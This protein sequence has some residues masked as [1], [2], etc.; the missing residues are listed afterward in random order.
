[1]KEQNLNKAY[2][3]LKAVCHPTRLS[4]ICLLSTGPR[5]VNEIVKALKTTQS[6]VSQ[7]LGIM[8]EKDILKTEKIGNQVNYSIANKKLS[9]LTKLLEELFCR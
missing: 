6:N 4:I 3:C 9:K 7:H 5:N 1:M 8:R 2:R